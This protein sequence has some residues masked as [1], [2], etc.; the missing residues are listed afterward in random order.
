MA[1]LWKPRPNLLQAKAAEELALDTQL[2]QSWQ[3]PVTLTA[4]L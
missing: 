3:P 4:A 2:P 1:N